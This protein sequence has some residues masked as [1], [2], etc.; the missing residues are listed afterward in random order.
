MSNCTECG[1]EFEAGQARYRLKND[2]L[3]RSCI[4][5]KAG[6]GNTCPCCKTQIPVGAG[7]VGLVLTPP[8]SGIIK[9]AKAAEV[10]AIVCHNCHVIFFDDFAYKTLET[11]KN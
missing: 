11:L 2:I 4:E 3:C 7:E 9:K 6:Q 1:K 10:L 8:G 5:K